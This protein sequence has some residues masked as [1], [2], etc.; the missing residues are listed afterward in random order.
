[1]YYGQNEEDKI[2]LDYFAEE[3]PTKL[4]I[5]D[6]GAN[7]GITL[8]NS[9]AAIKKGW[10]ACLVEPSPIVF[11]KLRNLHRDNGKVHLFEYAISRSNLNNV[12]FYESGSLLTKHDHALVSSLSNTE[13]QKWRGAGTEFNTI[14]VKTRTFDKF[15][16]ESP[17]KTFDAISIDC[18]GED[19]NVLKQIN[20]RQV[21]CR[22]LI[23][24]FNGKDGNL[25]KIYCEYMG[26]K[27][28]YSNAENLI[29]TI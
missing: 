17:L 5:L 12:T 15:M 29:F 27:L 19:L 26:M 13:T 11:E 16:N 24:E 21:K 4:N 22:F 23:V 25:F 1:M 8:S 28:V 6:I 7:D 2:L 10:N 3:D 18:E 9:Y 14:L 20:L